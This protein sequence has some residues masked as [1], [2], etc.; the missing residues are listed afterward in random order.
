MLAGFLAAQADLL[1]EGSYAYMVPNAVGAAVMAATAGVT[2]AW[3]FL[4][5]D[6]VWTLVS[7][8]GIVGRL[9]ADPGAG[10]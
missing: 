1:D 4:F 9:R 6:G 3:G 7:L 2:S 5:L 8:F 10:S